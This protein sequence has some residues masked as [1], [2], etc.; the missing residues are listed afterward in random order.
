M[1]ELIPL[2]GVAPHLNSPLGIWFQ[3]NVAVTSE[4]GHCC[5]IYCLPP[6]IAYR[7]LLSLTGLGKLEGKIEMSRCFH[8]AWISGKRC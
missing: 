1:L 2:A 5:A 6:V 3:K 8:H 7:C 4:T